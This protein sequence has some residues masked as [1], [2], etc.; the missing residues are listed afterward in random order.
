MPNTMD[1]VEIKDQD[2]AEEVAANTADEV[3]GSADVKEAEAP[4]AEVVSEEPVA[5]EDDAADASEENAKETENE[6]A[7]QPAR[8]ERRRRRQNQDDGIIE[9]S[10][11]EQRERRRELGTVFTKDPNAA[12]AAPIDPVHQEFLE[13]AASQKNK[14]VRT[15]ILSSVSM[16]QNGFAIAKVK[17]GHFIVIIPAEQLFVMSESGVKDGGVNNSYAYYATRR[18][19]APVDF[20]VEQVDESAKTAIASRLSA[21]QQVSRRYYIEKHN[22]EP[23]ITPGQIVEATIMYK[24]ES[25]IGVEAFGAETF[26]YNDELSWNRFNDARRENFNVGDK[27]IIKVLEIQQI[28]YGIGDRKYQL[29]GLRASVKQATADPSE[30]YYDKIQVGDTSIGTIANVE[31]KIGYFVVL[32]AW[33]RTIVCQ[34]TQGDR[35]IPNGSKVIVKI[36][37]KI[38]DNKWIFGR[39]TDVL[40][41]PDASWY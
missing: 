41:T 4:K 15:G 13:L 14:V 31:A 11:K 30:E 17:Y 5:T 38:D 24:M 40:K 36:V 9:S 21:M 23:Y 37:R 6:P 32:D 3:S 8:A 20:I 19:G 2:L 25:G 28:E 29:I 7:E 12:G 34:F 18:I 16:T 22:G 35:I 39:I 26:I 1:E 33:P 10:R 27:I